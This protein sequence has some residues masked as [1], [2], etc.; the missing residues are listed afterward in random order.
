MSKRWKLSGASIV[1]GLVAA[2][3]SV[4]PASAGLDR[5]HEQ[6]VEDGRLCMVD[7]YHFMSSGAWP[8]QDMA[9]ATATRRWESFT[10]TEYGREWGSHKKGCERHMEVCTARQPARAP[11]LLRSGGAS[12]SLTCTCH[13]CGP[14]AAIRAFLCST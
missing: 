11:S 2:V 14:K 5:L 13:E 8:S 1:A 7:H 4:V 9:M 10:S 12:L 3:L 6:A